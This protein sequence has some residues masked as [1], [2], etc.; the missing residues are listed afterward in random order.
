MAAALTAAGSDLRDNRMNESIHSHVAKY[1]ARSRRIT[2]ISAV[3]GSRDMLLEA[4]LR[5]R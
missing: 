4:I 2:K 3:S 5:A 1:T